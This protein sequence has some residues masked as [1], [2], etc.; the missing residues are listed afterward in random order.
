MTSKNTNVNRLT[1]AEL[2][3]D[4][5]RINWHES[6]KADRDKIKLSQSLPLDIFYKLYPITAT[7]SLR[8]RHHSSL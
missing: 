8:Q 4:G 1:I 5:Y 2:Y 7:W 3:P 6:P